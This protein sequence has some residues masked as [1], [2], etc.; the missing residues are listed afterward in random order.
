[1]EKRSGQSA[2]PAHTESDVARA[3]P[4]KS[5]SLPELIELVRAQRDL[6]ERLQRG[7]TVGKSDLALQQGLLEVISTLA[8]SRSSMPHRDARGPY[9]R[10]VDSADLFEIALQ[11]SHRTDV[12]GQLVT[13]LKRGV[14][15]G[16]KPLHVE[17]LRPQ[18]RFNQQLLRFAEQVLEPSRVVDA[19][20]LADMAG[21]TLAAVEA[22][23]AWNIRSHRRGV[24]ARAI[25]A[26]KSSYISSVSP[27]L[28]DWIARQR[29]WNQA[30]LRALLLVVARESVP[31]TDVHAVLGELAELGRLPMPSEVRALSKVTYPVWVELLRRQETFNTAITDMFAALFDLP[32]QADDGRLAAYPINV[33]GLERDRSVKVATALRSL[34]TRPLIS[35]VVPTYETA[36]A[37]IRGCIDSVLAQSYDNWE[38]CFVDDGS[39]S[40]QLHQTLEGYARRDPRIRVKLCSNNRGIAHATNEALGMAQGD[41]VGFLDHDDELSPNALGEVVLFLS[42]HPQTDFLY[43]DEDRLDLR[44]QRL[45]P[46][47]KPDWSP[48]LLRACNYVCHFLVA[49]RQLIEEVGRVRPGFD[50]AQDYDLVLRLSEKTR[51]IGHIP[52]ILYHWRATPQSTANDVMVKPQATIAGVRA[53]QEHLHRC[54][55]SGRIETPIPT[56]YRVRY[57]VTQAPRVSLV[58]AA[59]KASNDLQRLLKSI[60]KTDYKGLELVICHQNGL[61]EEIEPN[62]QRVGVAP[63]ARLGEAYQLGARVAKGDVLILLTEDLEVTDPAWVLELV[64]HALR[65][66]V[67]VVGPKLVYGDGTIAHAGLVVG[68]LAEP[69]S[70]FAHMADHNEWT[71]MGSPNWTRNYLAVSGACMAVRRNTW[72]TVGGFDSGLGAT[73]AA[74]DFCLRVRERGWQVVFTPHAKLTLWNATPVAVTKPGGKRPAS[75]FDPFYNPNL[76]TRVTNGRVRTVAAF[77]S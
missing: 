27:V 19:A 56:N 68:G 20:V 10:A 8:S 3:T 6:V 34:T 76:S 28:E 30:V 26:A 54:G 43:T 2:P 15:S 60:R 41:Y 4:I 13:T 63:G 65:P 74:V 39:R 9:Q 23:D 7:E 42:E 77:D 64:G 66:G 58:I 72:E 69:V 16:L 73:E 46:F 14:V 49:R 37:V 18:R 75:D 53:L 31:L 52:Q 32:R 55:E 21:Q 25:E 67:G 35:I 22:P 40:A 11:R 12:V 70:P 50:G 36:D 24:L 47:F 29:R 33:A 62:V 48:D 59:E 1:M 51:R 61:P 57:D 17:L 44:G 38:L 71:T 45:L 5:A